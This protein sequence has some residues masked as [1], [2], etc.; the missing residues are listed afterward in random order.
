MVASGNLGVDFKYR[1]LMII[2]LVCILILRITCA[3]LTW[4]AAA[5]G[6][7]HPFLKYKF[8]I[9]GVLLF[10]YEASLLIWCFI[11]DR[12]VFFYSKV[13]DPCDFL[14]WPFN[15]YHEFTII[16]SMMRFLCCIRLNYI[17]AD[18]LFI[19][20]VTHSPL[21]GFV[22]YWNWEGKTSSRLLFYL[23]ASFRRWEWKFY[24]IF[25]VGLILIVF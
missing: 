11:W 9:V 15:F 17:I 1:L 21:T 18:F 22:F 24:I 7:L 20:S 2:S 10:V 6:R 14:D 3:F 16:V 12:N 23:Y 4:T 25:I 5:V 13:D 8:Y 19:S